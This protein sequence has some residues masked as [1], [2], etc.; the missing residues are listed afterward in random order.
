MNIYYEE[1]DRYNNVGEFDKECYYGEGLAAADTAAPAGRERGEETTLP[2][3]RMR[4]L[5]LRTSQVAH[6]RPGVFDVA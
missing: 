2:A 4:G 3:S 6:D 1:G 5:G